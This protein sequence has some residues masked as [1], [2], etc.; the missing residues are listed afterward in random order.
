VKPIGEDAAKVITK[1]VSDNTSPS[2]E[3]T[4]QLATFA[5]GCFWGVELAFQRIPGVIKTE[6]DM[7][8]TVNI[9]SSQLVFRLDIRRDIKRIRHMKKYAV[10]KQVIQRLYKLHL[11]QD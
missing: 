10:A 8:R 6:V 3:I 11:H 1:N 4:S 5:A 7:D 2:N 9:S